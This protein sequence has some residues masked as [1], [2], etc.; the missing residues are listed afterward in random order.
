MISS[1]KNVR[2]RPLQWILRVSS[3]FSCL[4][5][6][7]IWWCTWQIF[8]QGTSAYESNLTAISKTLQ[9]VNTQVDSLRLDS[10]HF[11]KYLDE[12]SG[13]LKQT[14]TDLIEVQKSSDQLLDVTIKESIKSFTEAAKILNG[15]AA[16]MAETAKSLDGVNGGLK[17]TST[18]LIEAQK[19]SDQLLDVTVRESLKSL[20]EV[21]SILTTAASSI[22][23]LATTAG[24]IPTDPLASTRKSMYQI[25]NE[26]NSIAKSVRLIS[27]EMEKQSTAIR[28]SLSSTL[29][30]STQ[31]LNSIPLNSYRDAMV[32]MGGNLTAISTNITVSS[33]EMEKQSAAIRSS[34]SSTLTTSSKLL[35]STE[36]QVTIFSNG[37][38]NSFP[39]TLA[40]IS[41][42][43]SANRQLMAVS[44][45]I[46]KKVSWL[47][48]LFGGGFFFSGLT[49]FFLANWVVPTRVISANE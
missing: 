27:K 49:G 3:F 15:T 38:L 8:H 35:S 43:L 18:Q 29:T 44:S 9:E 37:S 34:L 46:I 21:S 6:L 20:S 31:L 48:A 47:V 17:K 26:M 45:D 39:D 40:T 13:G 16:L 19:S 25:G 42:Q 28:A 5:G 36:K 12:V 24:Q 1:Q 14:A 33:K 22:G 23:G 30:T 32:A 11:K 4:A 2:T 41:T 10:T 7:A